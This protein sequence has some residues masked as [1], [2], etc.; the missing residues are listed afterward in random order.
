[1]DSLLR[2]GSYFDKKKVAE[3]LV[4]RHGLYVTCGVFI[5]IA[6]AICI[7]VFNSTREF[8]SRFLFFTLLSFSDTVNGV[9][10]IVTGLERN[11][12]IL[13]GL[14][15]TP[16]TNFEC[17]IKKSWPFL[18]LLGGQLPAIFNTLLALERVIAVTFMSW[19]RNV[20]GARHRVFLAALGMAFCFVLNALALLAA[21]QS[22]TLNHD[23]MCGVMDALGH[24]YGAIHFIW[25]AFA[26]FLSFCVICL[27]YWHTSKS[28]MLKRSE[29]R[30]QLAVLLLTGGSVFLVSLP[31]LTIVLDEWYPMKFNVLFVGVAY[32]FY[33]LQSCATLPIFYCFRSEFR[34]RLRSIL[35]TSGAS[36]LS[37]VCR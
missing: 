11:S 20:W 13:E 30:K 29:R 22:P 34:S 33:G 23:Q 5:V 32:C 27:L 37:K 24:F 7:V 31:N 3:E 8:R 19:Y 26:Y 2:N 14:F 36:P 18:L 9:S 16:T 28:K 1:M 25:I 15:F 17:L 6:N 12:V 35:S 10:F 21:Y 4:V